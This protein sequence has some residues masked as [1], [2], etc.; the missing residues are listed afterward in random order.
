MFFV[1]NQQR[2]RR[3]PFRHSNS[4]NTWVRRCYR[5]AACAES[6]PRST[7]WRAARSSPSG[8][9][10]SARSLRRSASASSNARS[11][12]R[13]SLAPPSCGGDASARSSPTASAS[14]ARSRAST[15]AVVA[16]AASR[17]AKA[18]SA[19]A[20]AASARD[21]AASA[22]PCAAAAACSWERGGRRCVSI[23]QRQ[24]EHRLLALFCFFSR[25]AADRFARSFSRSRCS[26]A[27]FA[28]SFSSTSS[29]AANAE[30][31][32]KPAPSARA[33]DFRT[34]SVLV[35]PSMPPQSC[36]THAICEQRR[37]EELFR[38]KPQKNNF[39]VVVSDTSLRA[40]TR[41]AVVV[42]RKVVKAESAVRRG[43]VD[44]TPF[45]V[46]PHTQPPSPPRPTRLGPASQERRASLPRAT[47]RSATRW[48][49][50]PP[51][52]VCCPPRCHQQPEPRTSPGGRGGAGADARQ[53]GGCGGGGAAGG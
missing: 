45:R 52:C 53:P 27:W 9:L 46:E 23:G 3:A 25:T 28:A 7:R 41:P 34:R 6:A 21:S 37:R 42:M 2:R 16:A 15:C 35:A 44:R 51:S 8:E 38:R 22:A 47:A 49:A 13:S 48:L 12:L 39:H 32:A 24:H 26:A 1:C 29:S 40:L 10:A 50:W 43:G 30:N 11:S 17:C 31:K 20:K 19:R 33:A 36:W 18:V 4:S 5:T 14:T